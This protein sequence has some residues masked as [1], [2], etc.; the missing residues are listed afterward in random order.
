MPDF[1]LETGPI[2]PKMT[3]FSAQSTH[4][5]KDLAWSDPGLGLA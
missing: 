3:L 5:I 1:A 2:S 4:K